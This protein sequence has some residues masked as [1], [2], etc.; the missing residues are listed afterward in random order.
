MRAQDQQFKFQPKAHVLSAHCAISEEIAKWLNTICS[1]WSDIYVLKMEKEWNDK[2]AAT[3]LISGI[4]RTLFIIVLV[5]EYKSSPSTFL[6]SWIIFWRLF[7]DFALSDTL[8][9][10]PFPISISF[11]QYREFLVPSGSEC[12]EQM[13]EVNETGVEILKKRENMQPKT[14]YKWKSIIT[15]AISYRFFSLCHFFFLYPAFVPHR[16]WLS[17]YNYKIALIVCSTFNLALI[18]LLPRCYDYYCR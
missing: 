12:A 16:A 5:K 9:A 6:C 17:H 15:I 7:A 10:L 18:F 14:K 11:F 2:S 13:E 8:F 1:F 3:F 4:S